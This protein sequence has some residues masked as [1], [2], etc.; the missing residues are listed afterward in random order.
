[1]RHK[2]QLSGIIILSPLISV[3]LSGALLIVPGFSRAQCPGGSAPMTITYNVTLTSA[4]ANV[5]ELTVPQFNTAGGYT[6]LSVDISAV[7]TTSGSV[8]YKNLS[9]NPATGLY[10]VFGRS[11]NIKINGTTLLNRSNEYDYDETDLSAAGTAGDEISYGPL[12]TFDNTT[13]FSTSI[14]NSS[15]L[16]AN[17]EGTG[18]VAIKYTSAF[19]LNNN[20]PNTVNVS[21]SITDN[22]TLTVTYNFCNP[23]TLASNILTFTGTKENSQTIDLNWTV[24]NEAPGR[25]YYVEVSS[26]G[27]DF[28]TTGSVASNATSTE[29]SYDYKYAIPAAA[30]GI[31][32]FRLRQVDSDGKASWSNVVAI[33]LD[34]N[35]SVFSIYPNP[36]TDYINLTIPGDSQ[37]WQ[38]DIIAADGALVQRNFFANVNA[39]RVSFVRQLAAGTYFARVVSPTTG[40]HYAGGFQIR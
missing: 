29:A 32:Y 9:S 20:I 23:V 39:A 35:N 25:T 18:T 40:K 26:G 21:S 30:T 36:P 16:A 3:L 34:G 1:M 33:N 10:P 4:G 12:N 13:L 19:F 7:G 24:T 28:T 8:T 17:Y 22:I 14:T 37:D 2:I 31:L 38:V 6:L 11:D 15:T 5:Y 27:Q